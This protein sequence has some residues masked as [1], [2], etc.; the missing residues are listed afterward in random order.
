MYIIN[1]NKYLAVLISK[2]DIDKVNAIKWHLMYDE[3]INN[4][5]VQGHDRNVKEK[6]RK[7]LRLHRFLLDVPKD[8]VVDHIN[9]NTLD[10]RREN[11][12][13]VDGIDNAQNK[14]FYCNNKSG[15]KYIYWSNVHNTYKCEIKRY[16]K[17]VFNK[18]CKDLEK[19]VE[20][21]DKF[22]QENIGL[23]Q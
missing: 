13:I 7:T 12:R 20:M 9:R 15:Y 6:N 2:D 8:K 17:I 3:T 1:N 14:G 11:L 18:S 4:Y 10:N 22:I 5:Y 23:W 21:R 19:L 16:K